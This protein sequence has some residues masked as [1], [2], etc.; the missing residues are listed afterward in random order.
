MMRSN[1]KK[2]LREQE[3]EKHQLVSLDIDLDSG[4]KAL[5]KQNE[6]KLKDWI[7]TIEWE[8]LTQGLEIEEEEFE[9]P[10]VIKD[11]NALV[12]AIEE[13]KKDNYLMRTKNFKRL[14]LDKEKLAFWRNHLNKPEVQS[15]WARAKGK[16]QKW[17]DG[18]EKDSTVAVNENQLKRHI[19]KILREEYYH[20]SYSP[21][22]WD[23]LEHDLKKYID[24][25]ITDHKQNFHND[26]YAVISAIEDIL[27]GMF[28]R[29]NR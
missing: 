1:I 22:K 2:I 11:L 6:K 17:L 26:Q 27:E 25:L 15:V 8:L 23:L 18:L 13:G 14:N 7:D 3:R 19:K 20:S 5:Q 10:Q 21:D 16:I 12:K 4:W 28:A 9:E 29:V 24:K